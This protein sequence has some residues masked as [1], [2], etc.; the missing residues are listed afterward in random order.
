M[1]DFWRL[2]HALREEATTPLLRSYKAQIAVKDFQEWDSL[3]ADGIVGRQTWS[4]P[5]FC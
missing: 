2:A 3:H 4:T 5:Y 1:C